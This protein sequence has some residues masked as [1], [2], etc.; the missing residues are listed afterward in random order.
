MN[1][2]AHIYLS[3]D[4]DFIKIGNFI[5]DGIK[6][7]KYKLFLNKIQKGIL[8]HRQIDW[9]TDNDFIARKSKKRLD[10]RYGHFK[11]VIIDIL[12]DHFLAKNWSSYSENPLKTYVHSFYDSLEEN[13]DLL[14]N[15]IQLMMPYMIK[16]DWITNYAT[17]EGIERVLIG[18]NKRT[19]EISQMHLAIN[20]LNE[21]Y[22]EFEED[23]I[24]FFEKLRNF[25]ELKL[26][27]IDKEFD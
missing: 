20:D 17:L 21:H 24:L 13:Y 16:N 23:F 5:A 22:E 3:G 8:L 18:M 19:K 12:Y 15:K 6:G 4:D 2:L 11:G 9:F 1:Y 10:E 26:I 7:K 14:P 25:S 27:E